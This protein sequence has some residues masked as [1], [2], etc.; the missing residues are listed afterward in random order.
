MGHGGFWDRLDSLMFNIVP[1][2]VVA[3]IFINA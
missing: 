1:V 3:D 2:Y